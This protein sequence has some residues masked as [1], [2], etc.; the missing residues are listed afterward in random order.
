MM[1]GTQLFIMAMTAVW[2]LPFGE[3]P[4]IKGDHHILG[5]DF[6]PGIL[7]G[8]TL[9]TQ[10]LGMVCGINS[11]HEQ[12]VL[13]YCEH[14]VKK[15]NA[16]RLQERTETLISK[17]SLDAQ[18][19]AELE[20]INHTLTKILV[21]A[22]QHLQPLSSVPWSPPVQQAYLLHRFWTLTCTAKRTACNLDAAI[23]RIKD[24][25]DPTAI[26]TD[27]QTSLST[28]L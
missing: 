4:L 26:D 3:P 5:A 8:S 20:S 11:R 6:H 2:M 19:V 17:Q 13:Q 14:V 25:L 15:C 18:D 22:D 9:I 21:Q 16:H 7:F 24:R 28:K 27:P 1:I 10:A 12:H 23:Q